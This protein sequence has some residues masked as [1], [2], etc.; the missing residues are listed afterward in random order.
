MTRPPPGRR[1]GNPDTRQQIKS[2]AAAVFAAHGYSS[3]SM[4]G[5]ASRAGVDPAL[6][7]H[8]F[9]SKQLLFEAVAQPAYAIRERLAAMADRDASAE[10]LLEVLLSSCE[11]PLVGPA[12]MAAVRGVSDSK[13]PAREGTPRQ[14][15]R[16]LERALPGT[17]ARSRPADQTALAESDRA[18]RRSLLA[19]DVLGLV[20]ARYVLRIEP[21]AATPRD[22]VIS[23]F[24]PGLAVHLHARRSAP[25]A[26]SAAETR[27][28]D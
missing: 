12:I 13:A 25:R 18:L 27:C 8:Y 20:L 22:L 24:A 6:L 9:G 10:D 28:E 2:A 16:H 19:A 1:P 26:S 3:S 21:L 15:T 5:I 17:S 23:A 4:R 7:H 14:P 11:D